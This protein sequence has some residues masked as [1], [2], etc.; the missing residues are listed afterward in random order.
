MAENELDAKATLQPFY[1]EFSGGHKYYQMA[2][3]QAWTNFFWE[4]SSQTQKLLQLV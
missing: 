1:K 3:K 2:L 4:H